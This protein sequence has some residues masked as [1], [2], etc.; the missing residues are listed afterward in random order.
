MTKDLLICKCSSNE[1]QMIITVFEDEPEVFV[2]IHLT[3][4]SFIKRLIYGI[5][6]IFGYQCKYGAFEE[7]ILDK[8]HINSLKEI[9]KKLEE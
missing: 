5:K 4:Q 8:T 7:V 2:D 3:K 1:H 6:Y 9:I